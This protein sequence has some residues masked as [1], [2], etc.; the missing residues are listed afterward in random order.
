MRHIIKQ[1][2]L[3]DSIQSFLRESWT[4]AAAGS[5]MERKDGHGLFLSCKGSY[6]EQWAGYVS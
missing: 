1:D 6:R 2:V 4:I 3:K 5:G